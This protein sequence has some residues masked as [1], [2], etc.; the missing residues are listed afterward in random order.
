MRNRTET[1]A[2]VTLASLSTEADDPRH[3]GA[4]KLARFEGGDFDFR[5]VQGL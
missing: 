5:F 2:I 1:K 4:S 3:M